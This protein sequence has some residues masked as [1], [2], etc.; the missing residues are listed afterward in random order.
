MHGAFGDP[1]RAIEALPG[2]IPVV[3]GLPF[4]YI[5]GAPPTNNAYLVD[6]IRVPL[7]FHVGIGE[8]V[9]HPSLIDHVDFY[10]GAAPAAYG[11]SAGAVIAGQTRDPATALHG[12]GHVRLLDAGTLLEAPL[13]D[14]RV[15]V[16]AAGR[17][18]YPGPIV[19]A[20]TSTIRLGY[21]DYQ[22]RATWKVDD[23]NTLSIFAFGS[24]DYLGAASTNNG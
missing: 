23:R 5:R 14:G 17:Y 10:P 6:G 3:S 15:T 16:L 8:G 24:H 2:V 21:W 4:F 12:E 22:A 18:G 13:A 9:I 19:S 7:L 11:H 20:I 1:F